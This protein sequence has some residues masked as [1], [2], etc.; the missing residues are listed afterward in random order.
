VRLITPWS[1]LLGLLLASP[2]LVQAWSDP[3]GDLTGAM[4]RFVLGTLVAG[5]GLALVSGLVALYRPEA[6]AERAVDEVVEL[7]PAAADSVASDQVAA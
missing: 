5:V 3:G 2:A 1:L 6:T 4:L 7:E